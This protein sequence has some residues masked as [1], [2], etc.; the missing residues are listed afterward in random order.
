MRSFSIE[1]SIYYAT[2]DTLAVQI[3]S[4]GVKLHFFDVFVKIVKKSDFWSHSNSARTT[5]R[6]K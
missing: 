6:A 3:G 5:L 4:V 2:F 1:S